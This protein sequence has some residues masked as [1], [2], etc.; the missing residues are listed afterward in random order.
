MVRPSLNGETKQ[1][2]LIVEDDEETAEVVAFFLEDAGY[3]VITV[4]SGRAALATIETSDLD[5]VLLDISLPDMNGRDILKTVRLN[6]FLP[7]IVLSGHSRV[8]DRVDALNLGADDY[9]VK[10]FIPEELIARVRVLLRRVDWAPETTLKV[11]QLDIDVANHRVFLNDKE[12]H[13]T[14]IEYGILVTLMRR[15]GEIVKHEDLLSTVWGEEYK[16]DQAVLRVNISRLRAKVEPDQRRPEYILT[17]PGQGYW[18]P[19]S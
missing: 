17:V 8:S 3:G 15:A 1:R 9:V 18:I 14:P 13:L 16:D 11:R 12:L 10:P 5:L 2:I 19:T 7:V 6:S 4:D